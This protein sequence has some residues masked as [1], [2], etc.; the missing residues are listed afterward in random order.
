LYSIVVPVELSPSNSKVIRDK[1]G[2]ALAN[3]QLPLLVGPNLFAFPSKCRQVLFFDDVK[4][5]REHGGDWKVVCT[6]DVRGRLGDLQYEQ[7]DIQILNPGRDANWEGFHIA[8]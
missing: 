6:T 3:M 7:P 8:K 2:F 5:S 4:Y 1:Y